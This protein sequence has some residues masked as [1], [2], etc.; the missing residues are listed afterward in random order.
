MIRQFPLFSLSLALGLLPYGSGLLA[1]APN[2]ISRHE[3]GQGMV[4][5][6]VPGTTVLFAQ[7]ETRVSDFKEFA[8]AGTYPWSFRPHFTQAEN[9]PVVGV[10]LQDAIAYCN[11][12]TEKDRET[13]KLKSSQAYRL[14]TAEE[15]SAAVGILAARKEVVTS[16]Q[17]LEELQRFV[18]GMDWPPPPESG[19]FQHR[20]IPGYQDGFDFTA[21]VGKFRPTPEGLFDLAGN[22]WEW[23]WDR[24][25]TA[26]PEGKVRGGSWAYFRKETLLAS[27]IYTVPAD[28]RAPTVGFRCV[29]EDKQR[30][31]ALLAQQ[32]EARKEQDAKQMANVRQTVD[33]N[34]AKRVLAQADAAR[35]AIKLDSTS[36][37]P[38]TVG[39]AFTSS[40]SLLF[41]PVGDL[42]GR[43]VGK[44]EVT[45]AAMSLWAAETKSDFPSQPAFNVLPDHPVVNVTYDAAEAFCQWLTEYD[46]KNQL[47]S[48]T[49]SYRLPTDAEWSTLAGL[50]EGAGSPTDL[51]LKNTTHF[52]WGENLWPPPSLSVNLDAPKISGYSDSYSYTAPVMKHKVNAAGLHDVGGNVS[53]WT[54]STWPAA[55][56][57]RV[58]RGG[59]W[60]LSEKFG[61]LTSSRQHQRKDY[62]RYDQGFRCVLEL[63]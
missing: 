61:L 11:W 24:Q 57:E 63:K 43:L 34:A 7:Y 2:E 42:P 27:Y 58:I 18:W 17:N 59:S 12:L 54:S 60:L 15:W 30:T 25:L 32:A 50:Q 33:P 41:V 48:A 29:F 45:R 20:E 31:A 49:S 26:T 46:R 9:E 19:N 28:L 47:I 5:L 22:V 16:D 44:T 4:F 39:N 21:P 38:A 62:K 1:Q 51:H 8:S 56:D 53:E 14:P 10:N 36:L 52:A 35:S 3:S 6:P 37:K 40:S 55:A 23:T 13:G